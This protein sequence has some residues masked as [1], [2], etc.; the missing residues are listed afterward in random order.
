MAIRKRVND[1]LAD[2]CGVAP[3]D[4]TI[5]LEVLWTSTRNNPDRPHNGIDFQPD[6]VNDL[7]D[8][9]IDEFKKP[10]NERKRV[11]VLKAQHFKPTGDIDTVND[12][13]RAVVV[14]PNLKS[15]PLKES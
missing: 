11:S 4:Q 14:S 8:K 10:G 6:G 13:V 7:R 3:D 12:L 9:L 15:M 5:S 1:V 2:W